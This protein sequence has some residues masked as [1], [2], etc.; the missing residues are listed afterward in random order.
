MLLETGV[1]AGGVAGIEQVDRASKNGVFN[2][3]VV[4][5]IEMIGKRWFFD[6]RFQPGPAGK[7]VFS[8]DGQ[9]GISQAQLGDKD[10]S[11]R[12]AAETRM[13][14]PEPLRSRRIAGGVRF[15]QIFCLVSEVIETGVGGKASCRHNE[16]P[17]V[18][19]RSA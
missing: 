2:T 19:P 4:R 5:G 1:Q 6:V 13:K 8:G 16:L 15:E 10:C 9:L 7:S 12:R 18:R 11:V 17:F 14:F 3:L